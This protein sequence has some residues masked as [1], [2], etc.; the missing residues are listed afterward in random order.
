LKH[1]HFSDL[2]QHFD[3]DVG[4]ALLYHFVDSEDPK[5]L[6][7]LEVLKVWRDERKEFHSEQG[8]QVEQEPPRTRV[9]LVD[10]VRVSDFIASFV[11]SSGEKSDNQ[12]D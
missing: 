7:Q 8:K 6:E 11:L 2:K 12:V 5:S 1:A 10:G 3:V 4:L 9:V